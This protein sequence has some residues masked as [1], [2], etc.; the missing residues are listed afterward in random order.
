M[1]CYSVEIKK[2]AQ[3]TLL[4]LPAQIVENITLII[5]SLIENPKPHGS[6]KL[7]GAD[8]TYRIR[9][10]DYRIIYTVFNSE[11]IVEVIKVGHRK[12]IYR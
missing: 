9:S 5:D 3:K 7:A 12:E 4:G 10:G 1:A 6:K 11:L 8:N 2:S